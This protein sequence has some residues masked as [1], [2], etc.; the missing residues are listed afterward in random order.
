MAP[1]DEPPAGTAMVSQVDGAIMV[2]VPAGEFTMGLN[3]AEI[4]QI[5]K[6]LGYKDS[7]ALWAWEAL[8]KRRVHVPGGAHHEVRDDPMRRDARRPD[9]TRCD[10]VRRD[11]TRCDAM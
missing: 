3:E 1:A 6:D 11:A 5:A 10:A 4:E 9:A 7:A 8:P 2:Y